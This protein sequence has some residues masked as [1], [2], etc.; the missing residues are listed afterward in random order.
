[1]ITIECNKGSFNEN[2]AEIRIQMIPNSNKNRRYTSKTVIQYNNDSTTESQIN[3]P[4]IKE[5]NVLF[6]DLHSFNSIWDGSVHDL[7][8]KYGK[9]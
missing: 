9:R 6:A 1:M 4:L 2:T 5:I 3:K 8:S 7:C